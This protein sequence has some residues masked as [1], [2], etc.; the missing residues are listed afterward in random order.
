MIHSSATNPTSPFPLVMEKLLFADGKSSEAA[1]EERKSRAAGHGPPKPADSPLTPLC[2]DEGALGELISSSFNQQE[3]NTISQVLSNMVR[4]EGLDLGGDFQEAQ[5]P[6]AVAAH[7]F[8]SV[9]DAPSPPIYLSED[10][11][12]GS[13]QSPPPPPPGVASPAVGGN[14]LLHPNSKL[15]VNPPL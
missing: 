1:E 15:K 4:E 8:H 14:S 13:V 3:L 7:P 11:N 2:L 12:S 6:A 5:G 9:P 10:S